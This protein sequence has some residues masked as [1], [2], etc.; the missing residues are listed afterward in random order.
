MVPGEGEESG[1]LGQAPS[2]MASEELYGFEMG[3]EIR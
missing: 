2:G 3:R 1:F